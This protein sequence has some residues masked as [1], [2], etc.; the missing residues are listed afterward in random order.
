MASR[1]S[2]KLSEE[3]LGNISFKRVRSH[4]FA[5]GQMISIIAM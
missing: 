1:F 4:L 5:Q 2:V 3:F